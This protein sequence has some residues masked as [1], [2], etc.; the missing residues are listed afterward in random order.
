MQ[1]QLKKRNT[2]DE[3]RSRDQDEFKPAGNAPKVARY[4]R[5]HDADN[6]RK[7]QTGAVRIDQKA[8]HDCSQA[9]A[10][11]STISRKEQAGEHREDHQGEKAEQR[12]EQREDTDS[13][14]E[15]QRG[16]KAQYAGDRPPSLRQLLQPQPDQPRG[17]RA[18]A[19]FARRGRDRGGGLRLTIAEIDQRRDRVGDRLRRASALPPRRRA[20]PRP[21]RCR[22]ISAPCPSARSRC[23]R[24][25]S[26]RRR[27]SAPPSPCRAARSRR[28]DRP[29]AR[30][31]GSRARLSCRHPA[32]SAAG[33]TIRARRRCRKPNSRIWSS[34]T[35]VSIASATGSP[36]AGSACK[37]RAEQCTT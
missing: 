19:G 37:V 31:R 9:R 14:R 36:W 2:E 33:G 12:T 28:R 29:G 20:A 11:S 13:R 34:R 26:D 21:D 5:R 17:L 23:A 15:A 22:R 8:H 25:P 3:D 32:R 1:R 16:R 24:R 18:L 7:Q 10:D 4:E 35:W 27:A 6:E 30:S